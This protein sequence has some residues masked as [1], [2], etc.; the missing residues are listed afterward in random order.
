MALTDSPSSFDWDTRS[1]MESIHRASPAP[2]ALSRAAT[3]TSACLGT[4]I[5]FHEMSWSALS[6]LG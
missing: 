6:L 3:W 2:A 5:Q 1:D 4:R